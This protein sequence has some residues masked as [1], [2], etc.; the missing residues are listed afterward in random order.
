MDEE[1]ETMPVTEEEPIVAEEPAAAQPP[2]KGNGKAV[3]L[4]VVGIF[5]GTL[6]FVGGM[7]LGKGIRNGTGTVALPTV[8]PQEKTTSDYTF[9]TKT[10]DDHYTVKAVAAMTMDSVVEITTERV[11]TG[12]FFGQY[13]STGAGSG[14]IIREDG[15][16]VTNHHVIDGASHIIVRLRSGKEYEATVVGSDSEADVA[17]LKIEETGLSV[18]TMGDSSVLVVGDEVVAIGNPLGKLGGTVTNGIISALERQ[19]NVEGQIMTLLQTNAAINPGNSGGG[20]FNDAGELIGIV[21]AGPSDGDVE[22][23]GFAIPINT[24]KPVIEDL[25]NYGYVRGKVKLGVSLVDI[26]SESAA[27]YYGVPEQ[28]TFVS[29]LTEGG[30][31]DKAGL[32]SGDRLVLINGKKIASMEDVSAV[33]KTA[34]VGDTITFEVVR[35]TY[36][37]SWRNN[38]TEEKLTVAVKLTEYRSGNPLIR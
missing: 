16:V 32:K 14:V 13:V 18:A 30:D 22:G 9:E 25:L 12:N 5:A 4:T 27:R 29:E 3:V 37:S 34:S 31:A 8:S 6:L 28:G 26:N 7:L 23:I 11:T 19:I 35:Y 10:S 17:L 20:L 15:L 24:A 21:N 36:T 2:K 33:L 1:F 38:Y